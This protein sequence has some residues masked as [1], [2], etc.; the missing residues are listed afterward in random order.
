MMEFRRDHQKLR[1][2][3]TADDHIRK[4]AEALGVELDDKLRNDFYR[5]QQ[6]IAMII[7]KDVVE[8]NGM[9]HGGPQS[10]ADVR[11]CIGLQR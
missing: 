6:E 3:S 2:P 11:T 1:M 8:E 5:I 10:R 9:F 4:W 7:I